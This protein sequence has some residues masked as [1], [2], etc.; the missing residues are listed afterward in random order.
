[1][2]VSA[3]S[4]LSLFN[5]PLYSREGDDELSADTV[6]SGG[7]ALGMLRGLVLSGSLAYGGASGLILKKQKTS[8]ANSSSR[9]VG[10]AAFKSYG[11]VG[12]LNVRRGAYNTS[13]AFVETDNADQVCRVFVFG[14]PASW[15]TVW[16]TLTAGNLIPTVR[17]G[18]NLFCL[19]TFGDTC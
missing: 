19:L 1:M 15:A 12:F 8:S 11:A 10:L 18:S 14:S 7:V 4:G 3:E 6:N 17:I 13:G 2:S 5:N 16:P 9:G